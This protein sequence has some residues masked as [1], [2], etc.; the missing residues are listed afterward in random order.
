MNQIIC[1]ATSSLEFANVEKKIFTK[2]KLFFKLLFYILILMSFCLTIYYIFFRYDLYKNERI[3]QKL[4]NDYNIISIYSKDI[5]YSTSMTKNNFSIE[6]YEELSNSVI[7]IIE[8]KKI[9]I[10]YPILSEINRN[11]LKISPCRFY[12]PM[13]NEIGNLCIAAHNYKNGTFF[14]NLSNLIN[15]D[16]ITVYDT[17]NNS[18]DYVVYKIYTADSNDISCIDQNTNGKKILTLITCDSRDNN[19]R[20]I[21]K[22]KQI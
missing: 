3:S 4:L 19:F 12:G 17:S 20:T 18:I 7:G 9:N 16:I 2:E 11:F 13:P 14:S 15:G 10:V 6:K 8:I 22:A 21:V 5:D 1:T